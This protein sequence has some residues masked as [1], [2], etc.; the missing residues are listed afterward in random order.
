MGR[1]SDAKERLTKAVAELIWTGS[2]GSTT[3][4]QICERAGV[5]KGSFYHFFESKSEVAALAIQEEWENCRAELDRIFSPT[6]PPLLRLRR[7]CQHAYREQVELKRQFGHVLGCPLCNLGT[8]ISTMEADLRQTVQ[9]IMAEA[10]S[11]LVSTVRDAQ[12]AGLLKKCDPAAKARALYAYSEG[13]LTQARIHDD[14]EV[15]LEMERGMLDILGLNETA[16]VS[17]T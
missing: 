2:Y 11:Y 8:E 6:A 14:T 15:L 3:I 9:R 4:E 10:Q 16:R 12:A 17:K 1:V 5:R 7:F 13:L